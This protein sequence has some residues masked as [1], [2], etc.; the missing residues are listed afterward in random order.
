MLVHGRW[1]TASFPLYTEE[2]GYNMLR[3]NQFGL[4]KHCGPSVDD[5]CSGV[6]DH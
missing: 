3:R 6:I 1:T 2:L 5:P 4:Q